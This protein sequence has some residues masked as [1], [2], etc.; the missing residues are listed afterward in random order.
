ML[1]L[2]FILIVSVSSSCGVSVN[3]LGNSFDKTS[4][5][6]VYVDPAAIKKNYLVI[7]KGYE[8]LSQFSRNGIE[9][10]QLKAIEKAKQK[11]AD[12]ILFQD[13]H[14]FHPGTTISTAAIVDTSNRGVVT[15]S[16]TQ[17]GPVV[18]SGRKILFL[19]YNE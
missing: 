10:L 6:D 15:T 7:G 18:A 17:A 13:Y 8:K 1:K 16:N 14:V 5:I 12:A 19:K 11:G 3:Y 4:E 2:Y 9:K